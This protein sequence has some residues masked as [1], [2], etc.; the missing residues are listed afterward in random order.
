MTYEW[1][2]NFFVY[3]GRLFIFLIFMKTWSKLDKGNLSRDL[4]MTF[5]VKNL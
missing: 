2:S 3:R 1:R 4:N 5:K